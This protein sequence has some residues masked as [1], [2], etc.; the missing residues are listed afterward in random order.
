MEQI[1][2]NLKLLGW[3]DDDLTCLPEYVET[4]SEA[5][6]VP[7]AVNAPVIGC[8]AFRTATGVHGAAVIKAQRRGQDWLADRVYSGVPA[9]WVGRRQEIEVGHLSG[10]ANVLHYLQAHGLPTD[11][12]VIEAVLDLAKHSKRLLSEEEVLGAVNAV[13]TGA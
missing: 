6:G 5:V 11:A 12:E 13:A 1:L 4:V 7:I 9:S 2:V 8:D 10:A 3:R